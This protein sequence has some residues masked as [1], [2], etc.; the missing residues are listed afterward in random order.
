MLK[1]AHHSKEGLTPGERMTIAKGYEVEGELEKAA[2]VYQ[3]VIRESKLNE[4]AY[5]RLMIIYRKQKEYKKEAEVIDQAIKEFGTLYDHNARKN[6]GRKV[7]ALSKALN[8]LTGLADKKGKTL[9]EPEPL[10]K[11]KKRKQF[12][13]KKLKAKK[14]K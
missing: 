14:E 9:Y 11:W 2:L 7:A 13:E 8:T 5:D 3:K 6:A 12:V 4:A 1:L 10:G